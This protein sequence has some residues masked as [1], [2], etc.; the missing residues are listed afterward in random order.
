VSFSH[1]DE[2]F[3]IKILNI[4]DLARFRKVDDNDKFIEFMGI[5]IDIAKPCS[6]GEICYFVFCSDSIVRNFFDFEAFDSISTLN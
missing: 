4:G 3:R 5:I 1:C 6:D 2:G